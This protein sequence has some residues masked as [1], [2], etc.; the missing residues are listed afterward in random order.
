MSTA[1][2]D[3]GYRFLRGVAPY[4]AGVA[5]E[6]GFEIE[7]VRFRA[8]VPMAEGFRRIAARLE[9]AGRPRTA[10][11]ACELR[12]PRPFTLDGFIGFNRGYIDVLREWG[13]VRE[14]VN[15][16]ARSNVCP[17]LDPPGEPGFHA[18]SYTVRADDAPATFV[19]AGSG[20]VPEGKG[21]YPAKIVRRGDV[22]PEGLREKARWVLG[23]MERRLG[24]L[25]FGWK[26]TTAVQLYTVHDAHPLLAGEFA[27]RGAMR[28]G[29][30]WHLARPPVVGIDFET[31]CR[32]VARETLLP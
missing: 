11:C 28:G 9:E 30:T 4:S 6:S 5:A 7:R 15:P 19:V 13:L 25:G 20:E 29:L 18:F 31:D 12:S 3:G 24:G 26:D 16:V 10:L 32:G 17:E 8:P 1:F 22:T 2:P 27:P 23:E 14:G 21:N